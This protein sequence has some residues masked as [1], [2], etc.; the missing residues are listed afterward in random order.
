[1]HFRSLSPETRVT[2]AYYPPVYTSPETRVSNVKGALSV[3]G[4]TEEHRAERQRRLQ[5]DSTTTLT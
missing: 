4:L 2:F 5:A 3:W 1:M